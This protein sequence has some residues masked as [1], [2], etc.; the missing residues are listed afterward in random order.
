MSSLTRIGAPAPFD[1]NQADKKQIDPLARE[2]IRL[3]KATQDFEA[4]FM[5]QMLKSMRSTIPKS[6][7]DN[8]IVGGDMGKETFETLFDQELGQIVARKSR[9]GLGDILYNNLVKKLNAQF[10]DGNSEKADITIMERSSHSTRQDS[11]SLR[12]NS[13]PEE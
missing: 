1:I 4:F 9:N 10:S 7:S 11:G 3:K 2:K 6:E 5:T 13:L 8:S 12:K